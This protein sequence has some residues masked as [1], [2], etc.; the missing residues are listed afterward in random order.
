MIKKFF[1]LTKATLLVGLL[2]FSVTACGDPKDDPNEN[3]GGS[4]NSSEIV[5]KLPASVDVVKGEPCVIYCENNLTTDDNIY[6]EKEGKLTTYAV[7]EAEA[8]HFSFRLKDGFEGGSYKLLVKR[9]DRRVTIGTI[10]IN[11]VSYQITIAPGTTIYGTVDSDQGPVEGVVVSDGVNTTVTDSHGVYQLAS[12]KKLG[13]VF[14]SVPS[15]YE[16]Q[17]NGVFPDHYRT[18]ISAANLPENQSFT[19]K[20]VDQSNY[21]II[22]MGDMHVANR[23]ANNDLGQFRRVAADIKSYASKLGGKVYG[24]TLGDMTW[25]LYWYDRNYGPADYATTINEVLGG[26][27]IYHT[28]GNHDND[29]NGFG[30][31]NTKT[32]FATSVAPPYY[33]FNIGDIHYVVLDN[34]DCADYIAGDGTTNRGKKQ[35]AGV[36]YDP[37]WEWLRN[38]LQYVEKSTPIMVMMHVPVFA[39]TGVD[40]FA[41]EMKDA[42]KLLAAFDGYQLVHYVTGHTHRSYNLVPEDAAAEGKNIYEHNLSA[43][44]SDWWWSGNL[45]PGLLQATDGTPSGYGVWDINGKD[46]KWIYKCAGKDEN[47]QFR[48]YDLNNVV[49]SKDKDVPLLTNATQIGRFNNIIAAYNGSNVGK[50]E[51]LINVWQSNSRWTCTVKTADGK[52][53]AVQK[54]SAYDPVQIMANVCKRMNDAECESNPIGTTQNR[55]HFYKVTAPDADTDLIITVK[56]EFGHTYTETMER[57]KAFNVDTYK[58][59]IK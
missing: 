58:I 31:L 1:T 19:L 57:P 18:T 17:L 25:D 56:D 23:S 10:L 51:V 27:P 33:S 47:F 32:P 36:I 28:I 50:N 13:Y 43:I 2:A 7:V 40:K 42:D 55:H 26:L 16:C 34:V 54:V 24:I 4:S 5:V 53:L 39:T 14:I 6:L 45:T 48:S 8:D 37:Q 15:G 52:D 21:K 30:N 38:D 9:G 41:K 22:F 46:I 11:M 29:M 59:E 20:K 44:C 35:K 3:G 49:F 12:D